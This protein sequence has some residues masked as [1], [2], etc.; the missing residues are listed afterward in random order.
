VPVLKPLHDAP[1]PG[2]ME[3][4][5]RGDANFRAAGTN[6]RERYDREIAGPGEGPGAAEAQRCP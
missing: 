3:H 2:G 5:Q 6:A 4:L 1:L